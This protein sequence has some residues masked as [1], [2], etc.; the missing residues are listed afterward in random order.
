MDFIASL[1][2]SKGFDAILAVV[3]R[4]SKYGHFILIKSIL[5]KIYDRSFCQSSQ[6]AWNSYF[7]CEWQGPNLLEPFLEGV[8]QTAKDNTQAVYGLSL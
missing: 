6:A 7:H 4:H 8:V 5:S 3:D 1:P 2:R